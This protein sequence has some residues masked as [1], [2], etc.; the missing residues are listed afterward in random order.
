MDVTIE[1]PCPVTG[2]GKPR[3]AS[4]TVTLRERLGFR[5]ATTIRKGIGLLY[6][7]DP[8]TSAAEVLAMLTESY[9][10]YGIERWTLRDAKGPI[11]VSKTAIREHLFSRDISALADEADNLY[12]SQVMLPLLLAAQSSSQPTPTD[13]TSPRNGSP[14]TRPKRSR[15]SSTSTIRTVA[16]AAITSLPDGGSNSSQSLRS[17]G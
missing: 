3:H 1:C 15:R 5:A 8:Q 4:D 2:S 11:E 10:L 9:L 14:T 17:A 16:T 7:D 12:A 13:S 6:L